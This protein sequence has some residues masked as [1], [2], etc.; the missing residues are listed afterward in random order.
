MMAR[1]TSES[2]FLP[3]SNPGTTTLAKGDPLLCLAHEK[4]RLISVIEIECGHQVMIEEEFYLLPLV[5]TEKANNGQGSHYAA[6]S[7]WERRVIPITGAVVSYYQTASRES[8]SYSLGKE[9]ESRKTM[10][11]LAYSN[12]KNTLEN[13]KLS[14]AVDVK[15]MNEGTLILFYGTET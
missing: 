7:F 9:K 14:G 11:Y 4:G 8:S 1:E 13:T 10:L 3:R 12:Q 5:P 2:D 15:R 6:S